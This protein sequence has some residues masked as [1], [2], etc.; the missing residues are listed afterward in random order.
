MFG[1]GADEEPE[2]MQDEMD[3]DPTLAEEALKDEEEDDPEIGKDE[4]Y[5]LMS[6]G[7]SGLIR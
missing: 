6:P 5:K 1:I 2:V 7:G 4:D 3:V